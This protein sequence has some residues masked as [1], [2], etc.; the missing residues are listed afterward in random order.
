MNCRPEVL[1]KA[2]WQC[3]NGNLQSGSRGSRRDSQ[4]PSF[5]SP[6]P[7]NAMNVHHFKSCFYWLIWSQIDVA[8]PGHFCDLKR[9]IWRLFDDCFA[10]CQKS[11][12]LSGHFPFSCHA[13]VRADISSA[14]QNLLLKTF[15]VWPFQLTFAINSS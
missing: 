13:F 2:G 15:F 4:K 5:I 6:S 9:F 12:R 3:S 11:G 10:F 7:R 1:K 14:A 8:L